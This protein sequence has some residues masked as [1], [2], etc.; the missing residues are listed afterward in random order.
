MLNLLNL[1][2]SIGAV[3]SSENKVDAL[4]C[5]TG[6]GIGILSGTWSRF[7]QKVKDSSMYL[8]I[9]VTQ[10]MWLMMND[11]RTLLVISLLPCVRMLNGIHLFNSPTISLN[12]KWK[13]VYFPLISLFLIWSLLIMLWFSFSFL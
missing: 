8:V 10:S 13:K 2:P 1:E 4:S 11:K 7:S 6:N 5:I 12:D 3:R 9:K